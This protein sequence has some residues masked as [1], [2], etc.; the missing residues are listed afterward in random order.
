[1]KIIQLQLHCPHRNNCLAAVSY[2]PKPFTASPTLTSRQADIFTFSAT[3]PPEE[4]TAESF[5]YEMVTIASAEVTA[6]IALAEKVITAASFLSI[7]T[8]ARQRNLNQPSAQFCWQLCFKASFQWCSE[9]KRFYEGNFMQSIMQSMPNLQKSVWKESCLAEA[10]E[11]HFIILHGFLRVKIFVSIARRQRFPTKT[12]SAWLDPAGRKN[13]IRR[14]ERRGKKTKYG[15][16]FERKYYGEAFLF[17]SKSLC[18]LPRFPHCFVRFYL[19]VS[20]FSFTEEIPFV[21]RSLCSLARF[22]HCFTCF[23]L[24]VSLFFFPI[25]V[26]NKGAPTITYL[27]FVPL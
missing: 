3:L 23:F 19:S 5:A 15:S 12:L 13:E 24:S 4:G 7:T 14:R 9:Q 1:M 11:R 6:D 16:H 2:V 27:E 20:L 21:S 10:T 17:V 22:P 26:A 8:K 18:S 25:F